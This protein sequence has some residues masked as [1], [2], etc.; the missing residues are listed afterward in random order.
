[1]PN[2][3]NMV[4]KAIT[5]CKQALYLEMQVRE[6]QEVILGIP[7]LLSTIYSLYQ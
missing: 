7:V 2:V 6:L 3:K 4:G 1:G 5:T